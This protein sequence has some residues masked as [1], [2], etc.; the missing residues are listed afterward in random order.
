MP[1]NCVFFHYVP[2][3]YFFFLELLMILFKKCQF[4]ASQ[5]HR[6]SF[7]VKRQLIFDLSP[8]VDIEKNTI[9][10]SLF[11]VVNEYSKE[12]ITLNVEQFRVDAMAK[13]YGCQRLPDASDVTMLRERIC[14]LEHQN[15]EL[16]QS[17]DNS[18]VVANV[19]R[20]FF[21]NAPLSMFRCT[22]EGILLCVNN[23]FLMLFGYTSEQ[24]LPSGINDIF[25]I[26]SS[27]SSTA[28]A[29]FAAIIGGGGAPVTIDCRFKKN[30]GYWFIGYLHAWAVSNES[31]NV[32]FIEGMVEDIIFPKEND[33]ILLE[34]ELRYK[35]L[36]DNS[37]LGIFIM[38]NMHIIYAN[39]ALCRIFG[40]TLNEILAFTPAD[41]RNI[42]HE[43]DSDMVWNR[44]T[45]RLTGNNFT[46][47]YEVRLLKKD[48]TIAWVEMNATR[49]IFEGEPAVL[50]MLINISERKL[51][52]Q[53]LIESEKRLYQI[54]QGTSISTFVL[55]NTHTVT[56]WNH[57]CE[58]LTGIS[59][60]EMIGTKRHWTA[61]YSAR[62]PLLADMIIEKSSEVQVAEYYHGIYQKSQ[63]LPGAY[64]ALDFFPTLG[65][66]GKWLY[67]TAAPLIDS[68]GTVIGAI[69]TLQDFSTQQNYAET[70]KESRQLLNFAIEQMPIPVIIVTAT[71][72]T[73]E[74]MNSAT[75]NLLTEKPESVRNITLDTMLRYCPFHHSDYA[76]YKNSELPIT[77]A[78]TGGEITRNEDMLIIRG[79]TERWVSAN[80]APL[81]S[82]DGTIIAG[83]MIF[84]D[85]TTR[86]LDEQ[87][88][89]QSEERFRSL[90]ESSHDGIVIVSED[91]SFIESN[92]AFQDMVGYTKEELH[93]M[94]YL[95]ITP[96]RWHAKQLHFILTVLKKK[97]YGVFEKEYVRKDGSFVPVSLKCWL[98]PHTK[99]SAYQYGAFVRDISED[100]KNEAKIRQVQKMEAVGTLA[101]GIA[102]DFNNSLTS[103]LMNSELLM[104]DLSDRA[105]ECAI[106]DDIHKSGLRAKELV[107]QILTFSRQSNQERAPISLAPII[108][109]SLKMLRA[110]IPSTIAIVQN[111]DDTCG[112]VMA[113]PTQIHQIA[114]NLITNAAHSMKDRGGKI[115]VKLKR[116]HDSLLT[117]TTS[118]SSASYYN[119]LIVT[120]TGT[121]MDEKTRERMFD[122][123][124]TTKKIG[125]GTGM[126]LAV[127]HSIVMNYKGSIT[128][129]STP[130][131]GSSF[132]ILLPEHRGRERVKTEETTQSIHGD[133]SVLFV[134]DEPA[135]NK[136]AKYTLEKLGYRVTCFDSSSAALTAF[137]NSPDDFDIIVTDY[138]MPIY[139]GFELAS[140]IK[141]IRSDIPIIITS[142]YNE[143]FDHKRPEEF[144]ISDVIKKPFNKELLGGTIRKY[145]DL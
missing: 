88:L 111:Y 25:E 86:K 30:D 125:E 130:G 116:T 36:A 110:S 101:A 39:A 135:I 65:S 119:E 35:L 46:P 106:L 55:D 127:V 29:G 49:I 68:A 117:R 19:S 141:T 95:S 87:A 23:S 120:D 67:F 27:S 43:D 10:Y 18:K 124:F 113:N 115:T 79:D 96:K 89:R 22:A 103:I 105:N 97:G 58:S 64:E 33:I 60:W 80:A 122:P 98:I 78:I 17:V 45:D 140:A 59:A 20:S 109:D 133:E 134:D 26:I 81:Y 15:E 56:H 73:I 145:L 82:D 136:V 38:K 77:R 104:D 126:G 118:L 102:H 66:Q 3:V 37:Q 76:P 137:S 93:S 92:R 41:L 121:G 112:T 83:I 90:I 7:L 108:K 107:E 142:G 70:L 71:G 123:F 12:Y 5:F 9:P 143:V 31:N 16:R 62:R 8:L 74:M 14:E 129:E 99:H 63:L 75:V 40:Y 53:A 4:Q 69:E 57:A 85:I 61:F 34:N 52:E 132:H 72:Q 47:R 50:S 131:K 48:G 11:P 144:G 114:I 21:S 42:V 32:L 2:T 128:V 24:T 138:T 91:G 51:A 1:A 44:H 94:T 13:Q 139:T 28:S 54:I 6:Q 84:P 100:L